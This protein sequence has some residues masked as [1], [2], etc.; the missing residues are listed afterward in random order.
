MT[1]KC[2]LSEVREKS[3]QMEILNLALIALS[4]PR[5]VFAKTTRS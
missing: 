3:I 1:I 4:E 5:G 2:R